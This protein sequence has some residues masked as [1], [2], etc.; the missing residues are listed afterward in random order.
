MVKMGWEHLDLPTLV[1]AL[2]NMKTSLEQPELS[3]ID[4][5]SNI[6]GSGDEGAGIA[7]DQSGLR[8]P[9]NSFKQFQ[10]KKIVFSN[11]YKSSL[12]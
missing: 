3:N 4:E 11:F 6:I 10:L 7:S 2:S 1:S 12:K 9:S 8:M 5:L